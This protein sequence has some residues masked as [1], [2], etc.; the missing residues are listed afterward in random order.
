MSPK[1]VKQG[2]SPAFAGSANYLSSFNLDETE[3]KDQDTS[4]TNVR[5]RDKVVL[6]ADSYY[7]GEWNERDQQHGKGVQVWADGSK[8]EGYWKHGMANGRGRLTQPNGQIYEGLW[9]DDK[10]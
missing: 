10:M 9:V 1:P 2:A 5:Y 8:Y 3:W 4:G 7:V 6:E